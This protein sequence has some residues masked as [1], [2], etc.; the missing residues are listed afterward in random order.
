MTVAPPYDLVVLAASAGGVPALRS[1][2]AALPP[3]FP[4]PI[5]VVQH[6]SA[7]SPA[8]LGQI[9]AR[10][11]RLKVRDARPG[12]RLTPGTVYIA[13]PSWHLVVRSDRTLGFRDGRKIRFV[14]SSANP[15]LESAVESMDGRVVAVILTGSGSDGTD[16]VQAVHHAGGFVVAQDQATS[17][18]F[19]MPRSAIQSGSVDAV[20]PLEAIG[21]ALIRLMQ[22]DAAAVSAGTAPAP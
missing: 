20:L 14:S 13:P 11:T 10:A 21:P 8:I 3:D 5:A 18:V 9:L 7:R 22:G 12:D 2:L 6:R 4:V 17:S 16:G 15:L 1:V 19:G